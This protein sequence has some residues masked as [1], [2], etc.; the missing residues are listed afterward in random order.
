MDPANVIGVIGV[1]AQTIKLIY[2]YGDSV[3]ECKAE[4]ARL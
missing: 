1:V 4:V 3:A 2:Q